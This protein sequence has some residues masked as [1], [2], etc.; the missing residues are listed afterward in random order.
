MDVPTR[1]NSTYL[2]LETALIFQKTF[3]R[4]ADDDELYNSYFN[5]SESGRKREG[6]P[7]MLHWDK[8]KKDIFAIPVSTIASEST[9]STGGRILDAFRSSLTP[10]TVEALICTQNWLKNSSL[11]EERL[12]E[13]YIEQ[14]QFYE[15][16]ESGTSPVAL[17]SALLPIFLATVVALVVIPNDS[18]GLVALQAI[19]AGALGVGAV[20]LFVGSVVLD[21]R[22]EAD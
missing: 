8:A 14:T 13:S 19:V 2:M 12:D 15:R 6:P 18:T 1:W 11:I 22:Q 21:G 5:E 4:M 7:N 3:E 10:K 16:I 9:F 17:A 20:I